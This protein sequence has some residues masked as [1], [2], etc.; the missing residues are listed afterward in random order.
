M[1]KRLIENKLA[2]KEGEVPLTKDMQRV[3]FEAQPISWF[4]SERVKGVRYVEEAEVTPPNFRVILDLT[5]RNLLTGRKRE[6]SIGTI[7]LR[8]EAQ[9]KALT[10]AMN[11]PEAISRANRVIGVFD[12]AQ[13]AVGATALSGATVAYGAYLISSGI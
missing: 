12:F 1:I 8:S 2:L 10:E 13:S 3:F 7:A 5:K 11:E 6:L 4:C 9:A